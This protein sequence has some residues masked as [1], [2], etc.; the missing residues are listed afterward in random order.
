MAFTPLFVGATHMILQ[1][2]WLDDQKIAI[3]LTN[4]MITMRYKGDVYSGADGL[5]HPGT[6]AAIIITAL[7]GIFTYQPSAADLAIAGIYQW[8]FI[9]TYPDTTVLK[10]DPVTIAIKAAI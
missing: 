6:G 5:S 9:A 7:A 1:L 8:Q 10:S 2:T 4:A 3:D